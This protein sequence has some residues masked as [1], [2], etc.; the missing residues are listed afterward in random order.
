MTLTW[1]TAQGAV[2]VTGY[3]LFQGSTVRANVDANTHTFAVTSL[4]PG[5]AYTF[6]V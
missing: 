5:T 2:A 3:R 1:G 4:T 6:R